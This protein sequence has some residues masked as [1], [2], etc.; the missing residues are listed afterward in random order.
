MR[1]HTYPS[2]TVVA[3]RDPK[4]HTNSLVGTVEGF[5]WSKDLGCCAYRVEV[6]WTDPEGIKHTHLYWRKRLKP[7]RVGSTT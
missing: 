5:G 7:I 2:G 1:R 4:R 3:I 6:S